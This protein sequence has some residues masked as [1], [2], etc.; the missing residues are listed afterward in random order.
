MTAGP[1]AGWWAE[2]QPGRHLVGRAR[3]C[4]VVI[5]D[6][7]VEPYHVLLEIGRDG[8]FD[9]LQLAGRTPVATGTSHIDVGDSR[10]DLGS[11]S[12]VTGLVLGVTTPDPLEGGGGEV[13]LLEV[14]ALGIVDVHPDLAHGLAIVRSL[15]SQAASQGV[16]APAFVLTAPGDPA[17]DECTAVLE[18]GA[19][20]RAR[21][22]PDVSQPHSIR[23]H[24]AGVSQVFMNSDARRSAIRQPSPVRSN[25]SANSPTVWCSLGTIPNVTSGSSVRVPATISTVVVA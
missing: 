24:A 19:R 11:R 18:I 23:L 6:A 25:R 17:I 1:D 2:L 15:H 7:A 12:P 16:T 9:V 4:A 22:T 14:D 3:D 13:V 5:H 8:D 10:L 20:W 21:W